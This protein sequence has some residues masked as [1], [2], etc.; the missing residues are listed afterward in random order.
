MNEILKSQPQGKKGILFKKTRQ[1]TMKGKRK[2]GK[3]T[4][5]QLGGGKKK[6]EKGECRGPIHAGKV[7]TGLNKYG[8]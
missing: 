4:P 2:T 7:N 3:L 1:G 6:R 8:Y 5:P